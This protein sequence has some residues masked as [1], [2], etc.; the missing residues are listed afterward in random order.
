MSTQIIRSELTKRLN[1]WA[2]A[3]VPPV[4]LS[5]EGEAFD[6]PADK[7]PW[8]QVFL[9]PAP[10]VN[11]T[12]D[13]LNKREI[14]I[15]QVNCWVWD[16]G[17]GAG[18]SDRLVQNV[19]DLFPIIPKF[20]DVSVERTPSISRPLGEDGWRVTPISISYRYESR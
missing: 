11:P 6:K 7:S 5:L 10:T 20:S 18:K 13:G 2:E 4:T 14:G 15:F 17:G 16:D 12:V 3:Q 8:L 19:V 1:T 9:L